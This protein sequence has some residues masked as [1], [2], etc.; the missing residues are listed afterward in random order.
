[1]RFFRKPICG[2]RNIYKSIFKRKHNL[3][4]PTKMLGYLAKGIIYSI[5]LFMKVLERI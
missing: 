4:K 2:K 5:P 1:M 3:S